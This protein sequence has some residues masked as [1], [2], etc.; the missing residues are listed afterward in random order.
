MRAKLAAAGF[1]ETRQFKRVDAVDGATLDVAS[2]R[3]AG[4]FNLTRWRYG[5]AKNCHQ[6][7]G[8]RPRVV[9]C[10]MSHLAAWEAVAADADDPHALHLVLEDDVEFSPDFAARR[11]GTKRRGAFKAQG[12]LC[13]T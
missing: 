8:Y 5:G 3:V 2:A 10:A 6:D 1:A 13:E 7:H 11:A 4:V 12:F 9:G